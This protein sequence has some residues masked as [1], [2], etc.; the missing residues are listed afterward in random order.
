VR[1]WLDQFRVVLFDLDG[2][3]YVGGAALPGA[4][5]TVA[6]C[7]AAGAAVFFV[8]NNSYLPAA[9]VAVRLQALG[10]PAAADEVITSAE[11]AASRVVAYRVRRV[12]VLGGPGLKGAIE[13]TG[14]QLVAPEPLAP[15]LG[16]GSAAPPAPVPRS[17]P[18]AVVLGLDPSATYYSLAA[19]GRAV[20]RGARFLLTNGDV[21][22][23]TGQGLL[24]GAGALGAAVAAMTG[25]S[26]EVCGKPEAAMAEVVRARTKGAGP[27][28]VVGD[29][30]DTD[31]AFAGRHGWAAAL[32]L[33]GVTAA[34]DLPGAPYAPH[35]VVADL[36]AL[37]A[38]P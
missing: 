19:A 35:V 12:L 13:A 34:A 24:P 1:V 28:L 20:L 11:A 27:V 36:P 10:V 9:A 8:T 7:R 4:A 22:L 26:P 38:L 5:E 6:A 2:V 17:V 16:P 25:V 15:P 32:V 33:S 21:T 31:I 3:L 23:P 18:D 14:A 29:R 30:L 37:L